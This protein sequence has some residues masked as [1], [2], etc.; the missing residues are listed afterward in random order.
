M[1]PLVTISSSACGNA[2]LQTPDPLAAGTRARWPGPALGPYCSAIPG[3]SAITRAAISP[4]TD[5]W[6]VATL[7]NPPV[8]ASTP[9]GGPERIAASSS[10]PRLRARRANRSLK[11]IRT[12]CTRDRTIHP[13]E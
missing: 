13:Q 1:P 4:S 9:G 7:G 8:I 6:K 2:A 3:V 12:F 10:P 5:V 11:S